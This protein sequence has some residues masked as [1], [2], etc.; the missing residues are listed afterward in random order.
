MQLDT[1]HVPECTGILNSFVLKKYLETT[2]EASDRNRI[3]KCCVVDDSL[4]SQTIYSYLS[5][6][7]N[8]TVFRK[9]IC[10]KRGRTIFK[11]R[12]SHPV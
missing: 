10:A 11:E 1:C 8:K 12:K 5:C 9:C 7:F 3:G 4:K 6:T 2:A